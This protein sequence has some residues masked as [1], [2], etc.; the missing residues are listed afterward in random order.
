MTWFLE[1]ALLDY[2]AEYPRVLTQRTLQ[3]ERACSG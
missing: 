2:G 1:S 3:Y